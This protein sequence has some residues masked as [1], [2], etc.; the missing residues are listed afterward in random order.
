[1][2]LFYHRKRTP[3]PCSRADELRKSW[4][5]LE[6]GC[7]GSSSSPLESSLL[8]WAAESSP[9]SLLPALLKAARLLLPSRAGV[10]G[11]RPKL[12]MGILN[13]ETDLR[14][15]CRPPTPRHREAPR[16]HQSD[17]HTFPRTVCSVFDK[18]L[19]PLPFKTPFPCW[20][21]ALLDPTFTIAVSKTP[22][23]GLHHGPGP[24]RAVQTEPHNTRHTPAAPAA[25]KLLPR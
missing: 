6:A 5:C 12:K 19:T 10:G 16:S 1:M 22:S 24:A 18:V 14:R 11:A 7:D 4:L 21:G 8:P 17:H 13:A 23:R 25:G 2:G 9:S 15:S 20:V 3:T